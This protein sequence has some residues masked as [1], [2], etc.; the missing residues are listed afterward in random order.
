[1]R[2]RGSLRQYKYVKA[3]LFSGCFSA[4]PS[5]CSLSLCP[6]HSSIHRATLAGVSCCHFPHLPFLLP[7]SSLVRSAGGGSGG[8][9]PD[10]PRPD[11]SD[12]SIEIVCLGLCVLVCVLAIPVRHHF[13]SSFCLCVTVPVTLSHFHLI[14]HHAM[15]VKVLQLVLRLVLIRW[16][17]G[18]R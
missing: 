3:L 10:F 5:L 1:V 18:R 6:V 16:G 11:F 4:S 14:S 15:C 17:E 12:I 9:R 7:R 13:I 8:E 2:V